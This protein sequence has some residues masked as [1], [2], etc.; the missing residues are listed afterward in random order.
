MANITTQTFVISGLETNVHSRASQ[1][2]IENPAVVFFVLHGRHGNCR[3]Q[4]TTS[5]VQSLLEGNESY[6]K[7]LF[8]V[9][10]VSHLLFPL[11]PQLTPIHRTNA[12]TATVL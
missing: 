12:I 3:D 10:F 4:T 8:V 2:A 7:E 11:T 9:T 5:I 1:G 6:P